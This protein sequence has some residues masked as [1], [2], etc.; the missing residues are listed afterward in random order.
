MTLNDWFEKGMTTKEYIDSMQ[1]N[2]EEMM[3][4]YEEYPSR[5]RFDPSMKGLRDRGS[6][7]SF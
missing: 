4:I 5:R 2:R 3:G 1:V 6:A 7:P